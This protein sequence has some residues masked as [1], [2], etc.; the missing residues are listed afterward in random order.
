[1]YKL[2]ERLK[3]RL[4]ALALVLLCALLGEWLFGMVGAWI[5]FGIAAIAIMF[6]PSDRTY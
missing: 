5:G 3:N 2:K 4:L 1:M 6:D